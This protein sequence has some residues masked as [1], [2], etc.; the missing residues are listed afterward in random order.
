MTT[1]PGFGM[2]SVATNR[3]RQTVVPE[4]ATPAGGASGTPS[5]GDQADFLPQLPITLGPFVADEVLA[6]GGMSITLLGRAADQPGEKVVVKVPL[7]D[8]PESLQRFHDEIRVLTDL[9]HPGVVRIL[10]SGQATF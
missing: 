1:R 9:R 5:R 8:D 7:A 10:G 6:R 4:S 3:L 2:G